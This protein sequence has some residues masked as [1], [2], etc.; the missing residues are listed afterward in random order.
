M[1]GYKENKMQVEIEWNCKYNRNGYIKDEKINGNVYKENEIENGRGY[2]DNRQNEN[3]Y[4]MMKLVN[5]I[6][7]VRMGELKTEMGITKMGSMEWKT[8]NI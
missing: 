1:K 3:E 6:M 5:G 4:G 7:K 2:S 8:W